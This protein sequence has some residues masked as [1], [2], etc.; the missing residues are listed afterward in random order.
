[1]KNT[2]PPPP[3]P[4]LWETLLS[5]P[6][7]KHN[8][9]ISQFLKEAESAI[10]L[11]KQKPLAKGVANCEH[12]TGEY[13]SPILIRQKHE[14]L[15]RLILNLKNRN[16]DNPYTNFKMETPHSVLLQPIIQGKYLASL[17]LKDAY[18]SVP[19]HPDK[20]KLLKSIW[21]NQLY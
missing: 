5:D 14:G 12:E 17:N 4:P 16:E 2:P 9:Y 18:Y 20:T 21:K 7:L 19:I 15:C 1:M 6:P 8:S 3:H 10:N 13:I 11:E